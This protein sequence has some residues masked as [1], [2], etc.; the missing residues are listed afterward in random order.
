MLLIGNGLLMLLIILRDTVVEMT[1]RSETDTLSGLLNRRGFEARAEQLLGAAQRAGTQGAL[2]LADLD[3]FKAINDSF[4]HEAGD[5]VIAAFA[6]MLATSA[7]SRAVLGRVG[8]EE[9]AVFIPGVTPGMA[10]LYAEGVRSG[11]AGLSLVNRRASASFGVARLQPGDSL[12]E[13]TRRA[14][15]ALYEAKARGRD[16]VCVAS[17]AMPIPRGLSA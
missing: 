2:V 13:L 15:L 9:F 12:L 4:G 17:D 11:F 3:H 8:G 6:N 14:D 5:R 16:R 1:A 7:D 10:R